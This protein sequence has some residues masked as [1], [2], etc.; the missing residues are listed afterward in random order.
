MSPLKITFKLGAPLAIDSESP[1]HL[2]AL[3]GAMLCER[4]QRAG[5]EDAWSASADLSPFLERADFTKGWVWKASALQF[6]PVKNVPMLF[7]HRNTIRRSDPESFYDAHLRVDWT[8]ERSLNP[9]TW[10]VDTAS[11]QLRAYQWLLRTR[12]VDEAVSWAVGDRDA[13]ADL[14]AGVRHIGKVRRNDF[15]RV[16]SVS[17]EEAAPEDAD[18]WMLRTLPEDAT[19]LPGVEYAKVVSTLRAPYWRK[20]E[21]VI[22]QE[23]ILMD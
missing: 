11:G 8:E 17:V 15:G 9:K 18:R 7:A 23:P 14:L 4:L 3:V 2:D 10:K 19:G 5:H 12:L 20:T 21:R 22:A 6:T 16:T 1:F 13:L